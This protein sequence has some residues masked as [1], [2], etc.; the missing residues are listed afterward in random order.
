MK[1]DGIELPLDVARDIVAL[2]RS[3]HDLSLREWA[4]RLASLSPRVFV[5]PQRTGKAAVTFTRPA[6]VA[7]LAK[8]VQAKQRLFCSRDAI[9]LP[10]GQ[11][12]PSRRP[13]CMTRPRRKATAQ[14]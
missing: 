5:G 6:R 12:W 11:C 13:F 3:D 8:R 9:L 10:D 1:L 7:L 4:R 2:E 14:E